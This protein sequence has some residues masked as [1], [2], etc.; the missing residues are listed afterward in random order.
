M[1]DK[2]TES[3]FLH[4]A[5]DFVQSRDRLNSLFDKT[6][7]MPREVK[8]L[9]TIL[10]DLVEVVS[11]EEAN[12]SRKINNL[13]EVIRALAKPSDLDKVIAIGDDDTEISINDILDSDGLVPECEPDAPVEDE[14]GEEGMTE[15]NSE[16]EEEEEESGEQRNSRYAYNESQPTLAYNESQPTNTNRY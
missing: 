2:I 16:E 9:R 14:R 4:L 11:S 15:R 8:R 13:I 7:K 3:R 5:S 1:F 6:T 10:G 12:S